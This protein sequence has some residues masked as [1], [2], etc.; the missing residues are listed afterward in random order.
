MVGRVMKFIIVDSENFEKLERLVEKF[1]LNRL[2]FITNYREELWPATHAG[3]V[4]KSERE[5]LSGV[6][7]F[8]DEIVDE[9]RMARSGGGR[10]FI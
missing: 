8:M 4:P 3:N 7:K 6:F 2:A 5:E 1:G 9:Y 10:F